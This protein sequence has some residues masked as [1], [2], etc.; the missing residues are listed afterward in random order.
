M[1]LMMG[2][3]DMVRLQSISMHNFGPYKDETIDFPDENGVCF[4]WGRNGSGKTTLLNVI[5]YAFFGTLFDGK[6]KSRSK[7]RTMNMDSLKEGARSFYVQMRFTADGSAFELR[8]EQQIKSEV[9]TPTRDSDFKEVISLKKDG[10]FLSPDEI[11]KTL[12][13]LM[14]ED[15]SQF[16][17]FDAERL[18]MFEELLEDD[19]IEGLGPK[20]KESIEKILGIP[21]L[22]NSATL[23]GRLED[24]YERKVADASKKNQKYQE[25]NRA[26]EQLRI[27]IQKTEEEIERQNSDLKSLK[28]TI[29]DLEEQMKANQKIMMN[30]EKRN[31]YEKD[32]EQASSHLS[33]LKEQLQEPV[34]KVWISM[35]SER[36]DDAMASIMPRYN[37]LKSKI[38][39]QTYLMKNMNSDVC[40]TCGRPYDKDHVKPTVIKVTPEEQSEY[41]KLSKYVNSLS[42][43]KSIN[44][45]DT[46][47][48]LDGE[49][50][51]CSNSEYVI[52]KNIQELNE[53]ISLADTDS[54][55]LERIQKEY[56]N[57]IKK[58][59]EL[60][61]ALEANETTNR[62]DRQRK[63]Q[64]YDVISKLNQTETSSISRKK[65]FCHDINEILTQSIDYYCISLKKKV[66]K[67]ASD[68][69]MQLDDSGMYSGLSINDN[70][71]LEL[72]GPNGE[73]VPARSNGF[74]HM[75][76][77][78]LIRGI[79]KNAPIEG[80]AI[81]DFLFGRID[82]DHKESV[83][84]AIYL[85]SDQVMILA[86]E[87]EIDSQLVREALS[88][89]LLRE[90]ELSRESTFS[91]HIE[92]V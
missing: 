17:F 16:F 90:Y 5:K 68:F 87:G 83:V 71:G 78:S 81:V 62:S 47:I 11:K 60:E 76:A 22:K 25:Q 1:F 28:N 29:R 31:Q 2:R 13:Q 12:N 45:K 43:I 61:K 86:F 51:N 92:V 80:P 73:I 57:S 27:K 8:R 4:L 79:H 35:I 63:D 72:L 46:V 82:K 6:R 65:Q 10:I 40:P 49:L 50:L 53:Q 88:G 38:V 39:A 74:E 56:N 33:S 26:F 48:R 32:L 24:Q 21:I 91:T 58:K 77:L 55:D 67:D 37:E 84:K 20:I 66:E 14:P 42:S 9:D 85:L 75:I 19:N 44:T 59:V 41:Q 54:E 30:L 69:F 70:Y 3:Y 23:L 64:L 7:I 52:R 36:V 89:H 15:I 34:S 18:G